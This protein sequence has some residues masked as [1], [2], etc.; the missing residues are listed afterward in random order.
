MPGELSLLMANHAPSAHFSGRTRKNQTGVGGGGGGSAK[1]AHTPA[2]S[3]PLYISSCANTSCPSPE[4]GQRGRVGRCVR[5]C[6]CVCSTT[7]CLSGTARERATRS[8]GDLYQYFTTLRSSEA[9]TGL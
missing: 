6:V 7:L 8:A 3:G 5:A 1:E 9:Q 4:D 2:V